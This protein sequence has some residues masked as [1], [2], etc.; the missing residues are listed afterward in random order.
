MSPTLDELATTSDPRV[1]VHVTRSTFLLTLHQAIEL[2]GLPAPAKVQFESDGVRLVMD[3]NAANDVADW[4]YHL[5]VPVEQGLL[6]LQLLGWRQHTAEST[7]RGFP[8]QVSCAV[9]VAG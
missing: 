8:I 7:W 9:K 1:T 4:A 6:P 3:E 2:D 5:Q